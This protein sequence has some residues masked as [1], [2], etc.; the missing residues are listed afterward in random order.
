MVNS[1]PHEKNANK[2]S[3]KDRDTTHWCNEK[4]NLQRTIS[5][6]NK[7]TIKE[8]ENINEYISEGGET[9]N[10]I[11]EGETQRLYHYPTRQK[12]SEVKEQIVNKILWQT[13]AEKQIQI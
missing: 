6:I 3:N 2:N 11:S 10:K 13:A 12:A 8:Q 4:F 9:T 7:A 5:T 1:P